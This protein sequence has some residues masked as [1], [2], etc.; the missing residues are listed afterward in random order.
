MAQT[1]AGS[2]QKTLMLP[3]FSRPTIAFRYRSMEQLY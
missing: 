3:Y 1:G 2:R